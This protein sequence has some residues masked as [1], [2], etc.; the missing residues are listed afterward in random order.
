MSKAQKIILLGGTG[1]VGQ[2]FQ[3]LLT[4]SGVEFQN[5]SRSEVD[6]T[7]VEQL[8][9]L[10]AA[11]RP[12]FLINCA[13][14][15]GKPNVDACELHKPETLMGNSVLP[16]IIRQACE[17]NSVV[18]GHVSSGCIY[19]G[20]RADGGGFIETD[21]P[22]FCFRRPPCSFYSGSKALGEEVLADADRCY[23]W[24]LRIPFSEVNSPR[25]YLTKVMT[26]QKLLEAE[27]SMSQLDEFV[28]ACWETM[29]LRVPF[30]IYNV[31]QPGSVTTSEVCKLITDSG[32]CKK[33]FQFFA[34]ED[35]FMQ[36]A[37][38][39]PRSNCVM[40][41]GKLLATGIKMTPV[42][43]AMERALKHWKSLA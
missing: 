14:Y 27:N 31:T 39:T 23:L 8:S 1:Y 24:R 37:A 43:E 17:E 13:G 33:D 38:K 35:E 40:D 20:R 10:L 16:G 29:A 2:A 41:S 32:V 25:N 34:N 26:Y 22:N 12:D 3:R 19:T 7:R 15:T 9:S 5:V 36:I 21:E 42:V 6:Y 18:W 28:R 30:G 4:V 11:A